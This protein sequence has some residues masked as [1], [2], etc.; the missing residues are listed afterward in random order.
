MGPRSQIITWVCFFC[1]SKMWC[2][3]QSSLCSVCLELTHSSLR[4][5][6]V[7]AGSL[8]SLFFVTACRVVRSTSAAPEGLKQWVTPCLSP[9]VLQ[10]NLDMIKWDLMIFYTGSYREDL[11][12]SCP[13]KELQ[14]SEPQSCYCW[15]EFVFISGVLPLVKAGLV[16]CTLTVN[17]FCAGTC[18]QHFCTIKDD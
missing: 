13:R 16:F 6:E 12:R 10:C 11:M 4:L 3:F 18:K 9:P 7:C 8:C 1:C 17:C 2:L 14:Q 5:R 15:L